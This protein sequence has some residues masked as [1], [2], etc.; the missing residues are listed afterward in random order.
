MIV[1]SGARDMAELLRFSSVVHLSQEGTKG[2]LSTIAIR[3]AKPNFTLVPINGVPVNDIGDLL[4]GAFNLSTLETQ[5]LENIDILRGP[6]SSVYGSETVGGVI[7]I[8][9]RQ[10]SEAPIFRM[11]VESGNYGYTSTSAAASAAVKKFS[12]SAS[13]GSRAWVSR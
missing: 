5:D 9:L 8:H 10:P 3:A 6:L 13:G 7:S 11:A 12:G 1:E 2:S 4:G